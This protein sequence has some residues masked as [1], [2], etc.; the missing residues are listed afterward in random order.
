MVYTG[1]LILGSHTHMECIWFLYSSFIQR[2]L[3]RI[4]TEWNAHYIHRHS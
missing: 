3:D 2:E 4:K 1:Y